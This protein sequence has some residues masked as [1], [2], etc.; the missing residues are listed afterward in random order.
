MFVSKTKIWIYSERE[1][2]KEGIYKPYEIK[3]LNFSNACTVD[4]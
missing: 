3:D 1:K 2:N 4:N